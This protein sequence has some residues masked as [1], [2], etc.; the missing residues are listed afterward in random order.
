MKK[1]FMVLILSVVMVLGVVLTGCNKE[2]K[3]TAET[4]KPVEKTQEEKNITVAAAASLTEAFNEIQPLFKEK[5]NINV[6]FTF[7]GSGTLQKQIEEGAEIDAF[8]SASEKNMNE[9]LDENMIEKD[10]VETIVKNALVLIT[11]KEE[12]DV[13]TVEDLKD[14][15]TKIAVGETETVP[16]GQYAKE[17]L[18]NLGLWDELFEK[19]VFAKDVK[20]VLSYVESGEAGAGFVYKSDAIGIENV[21]IAEEVDSSTHTAIVYPGAVVSDSKEKDAAEKFIEYLGTKEAKDIL[22]KYGFIVE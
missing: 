3:P 22:D 15:D 5:E 10:T 2:N 16:A 20:S 11:S 9:L 17:S 21:T 14:I 4:D 19:F 12:S 1:R 13:K 6:D 18:E 8:I 7:G